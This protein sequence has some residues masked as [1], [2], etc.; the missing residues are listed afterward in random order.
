MVLFIRSATHCLE[1]TWG[2]S[3]VQGHRLGARAVEGSSISVKLP[4]VI[5]PAVWV[6]QNNTWNYSLWPGPCNNQNDLEGQT[7][8]NKQTNKQTSMEINR[9]TNKQKQVSLQCCL[10]FN[11]CLCL[12]PEVFFRCRDETRE[13][14]K[15]WEK[16]S[17][18]RQCKSHYHATIGV[19]RID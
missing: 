8:K 9:Q 6:T 10:Q 11:G 3:R 1:V 19:T 18:C 2:Q 15:L 14:K 13:R 5:Y 4:G 7:M 12:V 16:T 17:G